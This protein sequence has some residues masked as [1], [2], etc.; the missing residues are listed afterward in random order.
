MQQTKREHNIYG[1]WQKGCWNIH[2]TA[3]FHD[4]MIIL[5]MGRTSDAGTGGRLHWGEHMQPH[6]IGTAI[7]YLLFL[8]EVKG[9]CGMVPDGVIRNSQGSE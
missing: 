4:W 1:S 3:P 6:Q 9:L 2:T 8:T 7:T 5:R